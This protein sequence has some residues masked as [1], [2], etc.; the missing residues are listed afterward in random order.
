MPARCGRR[1]STSSSSTARVRRSRPSSSAGDHGG[2]RR[3]PPGHVG[4]GARGRARVV[5]RRQRRGVLGDRS[6]CSRSD[7]RR[8]RSPGGARSQPRSRRGAASV[9]ARRN[10]EALEAGFIPV[11]APLAVHPELGLL[12]VNADE[13]AAAL[14]VGLGAERILFVTDVPGVLVDGDLVTDLPVDDVD[15]MLDAGAFEGGIVPKLSAAAR[16]PA[17]CPRRDRQDESPGVSAVR[18]RR[19]LARAAPADLRPRGRRDRAR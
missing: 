6:R 1:G 3:R 12:N 16:R 9:R 13:A 19:G 11:V 8:D 4:L 17:G 10:S 2:V 5:R 15:R 18:E 14:A 7:R